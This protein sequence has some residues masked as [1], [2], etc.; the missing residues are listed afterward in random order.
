[1]TTRRTAQPNAGR[2]EGGVCTYETYSSLG[3]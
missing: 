3:E 1:M 2:A